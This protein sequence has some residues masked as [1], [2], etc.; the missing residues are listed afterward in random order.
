[1]VTAKADTNLPLAE[2]E[3]APCALPPVL[4]SL[5]DARV[6][7][8]KT[9]TTKSRPKLGIYLKQ[10]LGDTMADRSGLARET[11]TLAECNY[12]ESTEGLGDIERL[13]YQSGQNCSAEV[14]IS[15]SCIDRYNAGTGSEP[16]TRRCIFA[17]AGAIVSGAISVCHSLFLS[18]I[19]Y[20]AREDHGRLG[21]VR[22][23]W[24]P[25]YL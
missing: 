1:M 22:V 17:V 12:I 14:F 9:G 25:I 5:F 15:G 20:T 10:R 4:L 16:H 13:L 21:S 2:L 24:T 23:H 18:S 3:P 19:L 6:S 7:G 8:K 11:A